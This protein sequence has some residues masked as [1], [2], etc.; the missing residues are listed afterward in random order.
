MELEGSNEN[1]DQIVDLPN[2]NSSKESDDLH[3]DRDV[4]VRNSGGFDWS[5]FDLSREKHN[6]QD[7]S[8]VLSQNHS[9]KVLNS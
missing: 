1:S 8:I 6:S 7:K 4:M 5:S 9:S 2:N 3:F